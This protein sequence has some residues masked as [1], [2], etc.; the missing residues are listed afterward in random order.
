MIGLLNSMHRVGIEV[1]SDNH[2]ATEKG[3][4]IIFSRRQAFGGIEYCACVIKNTKINARAGDSNSLRTVLH[5][6]EQSIEEPVLTAHGTVH[7]QVVVLVSPEEIGQ[8]AIESVQQLLK[9]IG[10]RVEFL[11]GKKLIDQFREYWP[12][13]LRDEALTLAALRKHVDKQSGVDAVLHQ[14]ART[15]N[16]AAPR[17]PWASF[18]VNPAFERE[19]HVWELPTSFATILDAKRLEEPWTPG[20][21]ERV[22]RRA[23]AVGGLVRHLEEWPLP[24]GMPNVAARLDSGTERLVKALGEAQRRATSRGE[25]PK[26]AKRHEGEGIRRVARRTRLRYLRYEDVVALEEMARE[27]NLVLEVALRP[28]GEV[29]AEHRNSV[30]SLRDVLDSGGKANF[31]LTR[32]LKDLFATEDCLGTAGPCL[33]AVETLAVPLQPD[34]L[35]KS[36]YPLIIVGLPGSGKTSLARRAAIND[37]RSLSDGRPGPVPIYVPLHVIEHVPKN[38]MRDAIAIARVS[39][40]VPQSRLRKPEGVKYYF[41]GL[42]EIPSKHLRNSVMNQLAVAASSGRPLIVTARNY[43]YDASAKWAV[44][45]SIA[46]FTPAQLNQLAAKWLE[47]NSDDLARF[48]RALRAQRGLADVVT[49][50]LLATVTLMVFKETRDLPATK[51]ELYETFVRLFSGA[52]DAARGRTRGGVLT[53]NTKIRFLESLAAELHQK[54]LQDCTKR[55]FRQ[56]VEIVFTRRAVDAKVLRRAGPCRTPRANSVFYGIAAATNGLVPATD[57][58]LNSIVT[59]CLA[60]ARFEGWTRE[61]LVQR[62]AGHDSE[63]IW[64]PGYTADSSLWGRTGRKVDPTGTRSDGLPIIDVSGIVNRLRMDLL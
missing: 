52:W 15:A 35:R 63:A 21:T 41:D 22:R 47:P 33:R 45:V 37:L 49:V 51:G 12:D 11:D 20:D 8:R 16:V 31:V 44:R 3:K 48:Q 14:L 5:Q 17:Q 9:R 25:R 6:V 28:L 36:K 54:R 10:G 32:R 13:F 39:A 43:V 46:R 23:T 59:V 24:G 30:R 57:A 4:D 58:Q 64:T 2:G 19:V 34:L 60:V 38:L 50:P 56:V 61:A 62:I 29:L 27:V 40:L 18:Y 53:T 26:K 42:D 7:V 55:R 1:V